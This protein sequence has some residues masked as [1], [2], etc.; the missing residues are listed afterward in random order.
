[1]ELCQRLHLC[2][3]DTYGTA[4]AQDADNMSFGAEKTSASSRTL[5]SLSNTLVGSEVE[6]A[7]PEKD[8]YV[9]GITIQPAILYPES[10]EEKPSPDDP[11]V[12]IF[13]FGYRASQSSPPGATRSWVDPDSWDPLDF[14]APPQQDPPKERDRTRPRPLGIKF[15]HYLEILVSRLTSDEL[16]ELSLET[17]RQVALLVVRRCPDF[18][19]CPNFCGAMLLFHD[20]SQC[21]PL[22]VEGRSLKKYSL[23][24]VTDL[25]VSEIW[26]NVE[27][28]Q[29]I[30]SGKQKGDCELEDK[31]RRALD[32]MT[33]RK[34]RE[35][36]QCH[37]PGDE[38]WACS[39]R[40]FCKWREPEDPEYN[41]KWRKKL[42]EDNKR[43]GLLDF[44]RAQHH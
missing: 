31:G 33:M 3:R 6:E 14:N 13:N 21:W 19:K 12:A 37:D 25:L 39:V 18:E 8:S 10:K 28:Y 42:Q 11:Q 16:A 20:I 7:I 9:P 35:S 38:N 23:D 29:A 32:E 5:S 22:V 4:S 41:G 2:D 15:N 1:M 24:K 36:I 30:Y 17:I 44:W 40:H 27:C 34:W 26:D 43:N